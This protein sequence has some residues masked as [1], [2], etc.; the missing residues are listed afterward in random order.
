[1]LDLKIIKLFI[2]REI[3]EINQQINL[4]N[5]LNIQSRTT[6][7]FGES[8]NVLYEYFYVCTICSI[9]PCLPVSTVDK[10]V[11]YT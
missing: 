1:M 5:V 10:Q 8:Y 2:Q 3:Y 7:S 6:H 4:Q 11:L 9:F